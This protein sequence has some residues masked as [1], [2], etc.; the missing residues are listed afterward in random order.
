MSHTMIVWRHGVYL[1]WRPRCIDDGKRWLT[2]FARKPGRRGELMRFI[3]FPLIE[4]QI[5]FAIMR[6]CASAR[7]SRVSEITCV[8]L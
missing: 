4:R 6:I 8:Y 7:P 2:W 3:K 5:A 1:V